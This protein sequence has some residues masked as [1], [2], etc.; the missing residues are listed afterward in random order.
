MNNGVNLQVMNNAAIQIFDLKGNAI[1][2]LRFEP[3]N[4]VV[5]LADLPRGLYVVKATS[6]SWK[7]TVKMMVK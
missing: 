6:A 4:Y 5:Q 2:T 7:Q 1:R 3:G